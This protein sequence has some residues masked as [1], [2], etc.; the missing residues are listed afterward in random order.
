MA[1]DGNVKLN[2][3]GVWLGSRRLLGGGRGQRRRLRVRESRESAEVSP[4]A[5]VLAPAVS[6]KPP[7]RI[8]T[9]SIQN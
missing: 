2:G 4:L 8:S 1:V 3:V 9:G 5:G 7:G 6:P